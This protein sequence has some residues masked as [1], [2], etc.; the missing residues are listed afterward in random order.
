MIISASR[1]TDIPAFYGGWF[2]NR[3]REQEIAVRNPMNMRQAALLMFDPASV[4]CIV[5]W[6]KNPAPFIKRLPEID[7]LGYKYYF[8]FT[9]TPYG[10]DIEKNINKTKIIDTFME[11]S[12]LIGKEK[13]IWRYDPILIN[14]NYPISFH[15]EHFDAIA[16][17][18]NGYTEKCIISF[19]DKYSF[20]E[21]NFKKFHIE[22][23][24]G[25]QIEDI[26]QGI[27]KTAAR[28]SPNFQI[29]ACCEK[30]DPDK[31]DIQR[32]RCIDGDL[33]ARITGKS[34]A[35]KKDPS[36]RKECGCAASRDI[37]TYNT[38]FHDCIYCY[39]GRGKRDNSYFDC[40]SIILCGAIDYSVDTVKIVDLRR[41]QQLLF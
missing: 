18:I 14:E 28:Y 37:G 36:Q 6:T 4:D 40:Q 10:N 24:Q 8:Q 9:I 41:R 25:G 29:A 16:E 5:F 21:G 22:E 17:K 35:Y 34:K 3:L 7:S 2:I 13:V 39:A 38:C 33:I 26:A 27:C 1:R 15:I 12:S 11:L 32:G 23:P 19:I 31:Y 20:L 30:I